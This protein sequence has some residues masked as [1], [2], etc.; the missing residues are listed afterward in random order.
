[1]AARRLY[2]LAVL[3]YLCGVLG[4]YYLLGDGVLPGVPTL[5]RIELKWQC[6]NHPLRRALQRE[7]AILYGSPKV[8]EH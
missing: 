8:Y 3:M 1:M 7:N 2:R 5:I 4:F 6:L